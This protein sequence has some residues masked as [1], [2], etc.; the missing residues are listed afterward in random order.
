MSLW[1]QLRRGLHTL[2]HGTA[3]DRDVAEEVQHYFDEAAADLI[4]DGLSPDD[5]RRAARVSLGSPTLAQEQVR[6]Y[7]WENV[8][9]TSFADARYA[10]RRLRRAPG[11]AVLSVLTLAL[12]I[13][14][15]TAIFSAVNPI[16]FEPLPYPQARHDRHDLGLR[17]RRRDAST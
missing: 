16:L 12:G 2:T 3:A 13:G 11:F 10:L 5:A 14:A 7:G 6:T 8:V 17:G 4:R 15:S 9:S 1:R